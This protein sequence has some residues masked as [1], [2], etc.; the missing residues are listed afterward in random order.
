[1]TQLLN[2]CWFS[3]ILLLAFFT[4]LPTLLYGIFN[5]G[6]VALGMVTL[7]LTAG[8]YLRYSKYL[9]LSKLCNIIILA[10]L[11]AELL[12][13]LAMVCSFGG[14]MQPDTQYTAIVLGC[15]VIGDQP[16]L[17][18]QNR[19]RAILPLLQQNPDMPVI[20][21]GG[22]DAQ[23]TEAQAQKNWLI[24]NGI[25]VD[26]IYT[27]P[28]SVDTKS[29]IANA[30]EIIAANNLYTNVIIA[31]DGFHQMRGQLYASHYGLTAIGASSITPWGL[32]PTYWL[33]EQ[34]GIIEAWLI[35]TFM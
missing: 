32:L 10:F 30:T 16:S 18:L 23:I 19:L 4:L 17:M 33:R 5:L 26:R 21:T 24:A 22:G 6:V 11:V 28:L 3:A 27:E 29:N 34:M 1:M 2:K 14:K 25:A 8:Y 20:T 12:F 15:S 13:S 9:R 35:T 7:L 31:T